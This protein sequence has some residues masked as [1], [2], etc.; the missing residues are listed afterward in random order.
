MTVS[1]ADPDKLRDFVTR[2]RPA[3]T[4]V[5]TD[6]SGVANLQAS[7]RANSPDFGVD[8]PALSALAT[9]LESLAT[10][11][12]FVST[13]REE[14]LAADASYSGG[15]VTVSDA[16]IV[17]ALDA[18]GVGTP[19]PSLTF[20]PASMFGLPPTSGFVDDPICA[21]NGNMIHQEHDVDVPGFARSLSL[22]RT[23]NSL[24]TGRR[25]A[26]GPGWCSVL[27]VALRAGA[28]RVEIDLPDG[29]TAAFVRDGDRWTSFGRRLHA[30]ARTDDGG[31]TVS[32]DRRR[33]YH[34]DADGALRG[35]SVGTASI[36]VTRVDGRVTAAGE[37][38]TGREWTVEWSGDVVTALVTNDGRRV[39][40]GYDDDGFLARVGA[41]A[42]EV[43]YGWAAGFLVSVTD[44]DG[45]QSFLNEYDDDGR[46][47][48]QTSPFGRV[49]DY[50]YDPSGLTVITDERGVRQAMVHDGRG[51]LT[52]VIDVDGTAMRL[53]YDHLDRV[54]QVDDRNGAVWQYRYDPARDELVER[55]DPDGLTAAWEWDDD[56]R[57]LASTDRRGAATTYEYTGSL[58][59]PSRIID[60]AGAV[61][62]IQVDPR[63]D[64]PA[65]VTDADGVTTVIETDADGQVTAIVDAL[66]NRTEMAYDSAGRPVRGTDA[67]EVATELVYDDRGWMV[68]A[69][70]AGRVST[71]VRTAAGRIGGGS[72][73]GEQ[74][75]SALFGPHGAPVGITDAL[76]NTVG[77]E[78]DTMGNVVALTA[79]DGARCEQ[80]FDAVGRLVAITDPSGATTHQRY[81]RAGHLVEIEDAAGNV[82]RRDVDLFGRTVRSIAADGRATSFTYHPN[83]EIATLTSPDGRSWVTELDAV[84]RVVAVVDPVGG[85]AEVTYS[86]AG[87]LIERRSPAGRTE[88][89][90]HDAT[91][92][93]LATVDARG[94]RHEMSR[95]A[96]G[97]VEAAVRE[98]E[99]GSRTITWDEQ[100]NIAAVV[101]ARGSLAF[102]HDVAGHL[103]ATVDGSGART[104][105][106]WDRRGLL[107]GA[108]D[109][110]GGRIAY[111]YDGRGRVTSQTAPG[112]RTT[113][114]EYDA[115]GRAATV[116]DPAGVTTRLTRDAVGRL[117]GLDRGDAGWRRR[118]D[119]V[120]RELERTDLAGDLLAGYRYDA[121]G[122]LAEA[123]APNG[124]FSSFLWDAG[125]RITT[126][127]DVTGTTTIE[128]DA[129]GWAVA[130][131][132]PSGVRT[133][134][135]RDPAGRIVRVLDD[136]AGEV[137]VPIDPLEFDPAGR[138]LLGPDG[139]V[140]RYDDAGRLAE[141]VPPSGATVTYEYGEDGL[142][143]VERG[144]L[145]R[146]FGYDAAGRVASVAVDGVGTTAISYDDAG[147][148]AREVGPDGTATAY[149]W[150]GLD[151]LVGIVRTEP[152]GRTTSV[153]IDVDALGRPGR[154]NG[155]P[156]GYD[157][158]G[159]L[160]N[161]IGD[162]RIVNLPKVGHGGV[163]WRSDDRAWGRQGA[164]ATQGLKIGPWT[165]LG[166]RVHDS[167]THQF[168]SADPLGVVP[169]TNGAASAYTYAWQDPVNFVDP[170][171]MRP[172]SQ[173]EWD[174]IRT[175]EEQGRV[176]QMVQAIKDDP[177]G[178]IAA[179]LVIVGGVVLLAT[180]L[181]PI[182]AGILIGAGMAAGMGF[183]TGTFDP[184][185]VV[186]GGVIGGVTAGAG[187]VAANIGNTAARTAFTVGAGTLVGAG[188]ELGNQVISGQPIDWQSVGVNGLVSGATF[189]VGG[190]LQTMTSSVRQGVV[191]GAVTDGTG[192]L[193]TQ[194]LTGDGSID[195]AE[196]LTATGSGGALGGSEHYFGARHQQLE[197]P[198]GQLALEAG[199]QRL[200]LTAGDGP[201]M[202][203]VYRG[204]SFGS[205]HAI[206]R[207]T[208]MMMSDAARD[209]YMGT[210]GDVDIAHSYSMSA[211]Q[212][213]VDIWGSEGDYVEAHSAFERS[214]LESVSGS[215]TMV[216]VSTDPD[217]ARIFAGKDGI[218]YRAEVPADSL[219][220]QTL[221]GAGESEYLAPH[222][223]RMDQHDPA[224]SPGS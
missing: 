31:W 79:P 138:L 82:T 57:L 156:I 173:E 178:S 61:T 125:D 62:T 177:W 80:R 29:A 102:E 63:I 97:R 74:A 117:I 59:T 162:V 206:Q 207:E 71:Y 197:V 220:R 73:P 120:G 159:G 12:T 83:G 154:V 32:T 222:S 133:I 134:F 69:E 135:E 33:A 136:E 87:R 94:V 179:G 18:A 181:A 72:E 223:I 158:A 199:P 152:G 182:G 81:D 30:L 221:D 52:S 146:R 34:F 2:S 200:M 191:Y 174:G 88:R 99:P 168:L 114:W 171:G 112:G 208:G 101:A 22:V 36:G 131:T 202:I 108:V 144:A 106:E 98:G 176:G 119:L 193:V 118:L 41:D 186:L 1:S 104:E 35:W 139:T 26:F 213:A 211:H 214:E 204:T 160:P 167:L 175:L 192:N 128:R 6:R 95:D 155:R 215:R 189:G 111:E 103:L 10:N 48:R 210:G 92:R 56:G 93:L 153:T 24:P 38:T 85:R 194:R 209:A 27:D 185:Q 25:G 187:S 3:R 183:A 217:Q 105:F 184:R 170:S 20:E 166:A 9:L 23:Y 107:I 46:V 147:R 216:S 49:T 4:T 55:R 126:V 124:L 58:S 21:A 84:G 129:D 109:P 201:E 130:M 43:V 148:R 64:Q 219:I 77:L 76:G 132:Q 165:M 196:F 127:T 141:V 198:P 89:F 110:A 172:I 28:D 169:G 150:A 39:R 51:N 218:V 86:A 122:R 47:V 203:T 42:G 37:P 115:A 65:R 75:W 224:P 78:Y 11:E 140:Y 7:V 137:R 66:G 151:Q 60:P 180:P 116:V 67:L 100:G 53:T 163:S 212:R 164:E 113:S 8:A 16:A 143:A 96:V 44:A 50:R 17:A 14:L 190:R 90:E 121:A 40:Y 19:P 54:V 15:T 195:M 157:P 161:R 91:G 45:V 70:R 68:R 142:L 205:E 188:N 13:I 145:V 149:R 5:A 123:T